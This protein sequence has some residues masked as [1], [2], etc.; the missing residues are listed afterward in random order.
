MCNF[1]TN[2]GASTM[3]TMQANRN[4]DFEW[5]LWTGKTPSADTGPAKAFNG[6]YYIYA[7]ASAPRVNGDMAELVFII[8]CNNYYTTRELFI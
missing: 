1:E 7:E 6:P 3:C 4:M 8:T 2:D 5:T